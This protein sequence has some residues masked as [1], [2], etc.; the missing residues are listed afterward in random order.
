M[1]NLKL[2]LVLSTI[3]EDDDKG[4]AANAYLVDLGFSESPV[5]NEQEIA[6]NNNDELHPTTVE[7]AYK[8][9]MEITTEWTHVM[10]FQECG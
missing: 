2:L 9:E 5:L 8:V 1:V 3:H 4:D 10:S 7:Y 6:Q